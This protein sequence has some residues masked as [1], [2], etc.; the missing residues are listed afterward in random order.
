MFLQHPHPSSLPLKQDLKGETQEEV[1]K[2]MI[3]S[4]PV[5]TI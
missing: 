5:F 3:L 4:S 1:G 2:A